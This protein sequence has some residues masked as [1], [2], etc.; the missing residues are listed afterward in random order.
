MFP[1]SSTMNQLERIVQVT[2]ACF[3]RPLHPA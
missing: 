1:G 2:G 3:L